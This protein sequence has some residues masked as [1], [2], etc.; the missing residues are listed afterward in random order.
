MDHAGRWNLVSGKIEK[1]SERAVLVDEEL[2][3]K[4]A[5]KGSLA[6]S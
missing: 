2:G 6:V 5:N 4:K 3:G 1:M